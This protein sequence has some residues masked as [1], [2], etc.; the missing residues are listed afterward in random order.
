MLKTM[1]QKM[2]PAEEFI[3]G[4]L[5]GTIVTSA[6]VR[7]TIERHERDL[8][9]GHLRGLRFDRKKA[10][11]VIDFFGFLRHSKGEW[12]G[13][14][15]ILEPWQQAFIWILFGWVHADTSLRRFRFS[16]TELARGNGKSTLA[17]GVALFLLAAD[18]EGGAEIYSAATKK[19]QARIVFSESER[20]VKSSPALR[21]KIATFRDNLHIVGTA[22]KYQ[23]LSS[24]K[25]S[26]DGLNIHGVIAD[27]VHAWKGRALWDVLVT[28]LGKRRQSLLF[29]ITTAGYDKHS[30]CFEQH[31][32][33]EKVLAGIIEDDTWFCWIAGLDDEDDWED[34]SNWIK[35]NPALGTM[36]K[37]EELRTA[38]A[39]AKE[40]PG[41]LNAF[42]RL[43]LNKWTSQHTLWMPMDR[44]DSCNAAFTPESL[45]GRECFAGLDLSTTTDISALVLLFPPIETD[46][47]WYVL[48]HF[49]IPSENIEDRVKRDR[50]PYDVWKKQGHLITTDGNV[51]DYDAIRLKVNELGQLYN[52][53][54]LMFDRWNATQ[55]TTQLAGDGFETVQF[56]QGFTSMNAPTKRL[57]ELVLSSELA[58]GGNPV[59]R[60]MASNV[61]VKQDPAGNLKPDKSKSTEKIDG[62]VALCMA[63]GRASVATP[64]PIPAGIFFA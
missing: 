47:R 17:S 33:S 8:D 16:Y 37:I 10:Q 29:A 52:I 38:A 25:D 43:R 9:F 1:K 36:V 61:T 11:R 7:Q 21:A 49:F 19:D 32:Y 5:D 28:A 12:A 23:P 4:V 64:T 55:L 3:E 13:H 41:S 26:L 46:K 15:F 44:W 34:E 42:L 18:G 35:A 24:D 22:S 54:E 62:I 6:L 30:V 59:L 50:V 39:K 31:G 27:E 51:I 20:M 56:G 60:W 45:H 58:H 48:P 63:L 2:S 40:T 14:K 57:L 53:R